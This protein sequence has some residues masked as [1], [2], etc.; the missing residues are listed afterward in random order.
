VGDIRLALAGLGAWAPPTSEPPACAWLC[1]EGTFTIPDEQ[2]RPV[3]AAA[4]ALAA[5]G[6]DVSEAPLDL[7]AAAEPLFSALRARDDYRD[8]RALATGRSGML[9]ERI[10]GLLETEPSREPP[11]AEL[12]RQ[13]AA[14]RLGVLE[15]MRSRPILLLPIAATGALATG[16]DVVEIAGALTPVNDMKMLAPC[17]AISVLGLPALSLPAGGDRD[18]LPIGIQIVGR[19][20]GESDVLAVAEFLADVAVPEHRT[21]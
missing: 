11:I 20:G 18:G 13:L 19:P 6:H 15:F 8:I 14:V 10:A 17:R 5:A 21:V 16:A 4:H 2:A 12:E 3:R 7:I 9:S 1:G